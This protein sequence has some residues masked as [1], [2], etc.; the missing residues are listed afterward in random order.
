MI[1]RRLTTMVL[2]AASTLLIVG[3]LTGGAVKV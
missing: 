3:R 1:W 2:S